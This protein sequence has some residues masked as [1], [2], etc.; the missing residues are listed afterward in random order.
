MN[1]SDLIM[2]RYSCRKYLSKRI[3]RKIIDQCLEAGR[4]APSACNSQPW[5][6]IIVDDPDKKDQLVKKT[7]SGIYSSNS[8]VASAPALIVVNRLKSTYTARLGGMIRNVKYSLIDIGIACDHITLAAAE[9]G[10]ATC[11]LGWFNDKKLKTSLNLKKSSNIE[12]I[13]AIGYP[14]N[15]TR[16][17]TKERKSLDKTRRYY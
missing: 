6:F 8:F 7:M 3:P 10:L 17:P 5:E 11:W 12:I 9:I 16:P 13:L 4:L 2:Q 14:D 15:S 1:F